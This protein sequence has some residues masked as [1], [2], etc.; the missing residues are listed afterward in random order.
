MH[1]IET[2]ITEAASNLGIPIRKLTNGEAESVLHEAMSR[3]VKMADPRSWWLSLA[4]P[5]DEHY[6]RRLVKLSSIL[7]TT[8]GTV[9]FIPETDA[10]H[11][12]VY[13]MEVGL[14]E[15]LIDDCPGF[16]Y[17]VVAKDFSWLVIETDH[18]QYYVCRDS[19]KLPEFD[20]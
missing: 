18:D 7:P 19:D 13:E 17:N 8:T 2:W 9:W 15:K 16:E 20:H 4:R 1:E 11:L 14:V 12:P 6:D 10:R 3:Y 5:I